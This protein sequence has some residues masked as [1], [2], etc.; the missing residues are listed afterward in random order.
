MGHSHLSARLGRER[1]PIPLL[2]PSCHRGSLTI[3]TASTTTTRRHPSGRPQRLGARKRSQG[4]RPK[5]PLRPARNE[6]SCTHSARAKRTHRLCRRSRNEHVV[7]SPKVAKRT[8]SFRLLLVRNEPVVPGASSRNEPQP[9]LQ[10]PTNEGLSAQ[11]R[12]APQRAP[13]RTGPR[14]SPADKAHPPE[15]LAS[16]EGAPRG[17]PEGARRDACG[18]V[19]QSRTLQLNS[20]GPDSAVPRRR[21]RP[22]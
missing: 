7:A 10:P 21:C 12:S 14:T 1:P 3:R 15:T 6:P 22:A 20:C 4:I 13:K 2:G 19:S 8:R 11:P 5:M 16:P 17:A 18:S 9:S